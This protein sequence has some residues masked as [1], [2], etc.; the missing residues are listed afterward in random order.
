MNLIEHNIPAG[1]FWLCYC[2]NPLH[3]ILFAQCDSHWRVRCKVRHTPPM[4][5]DPV[6]TCPCGQHD[7]PR[8]LG[9]MDRPSRPHQRRADADS[10]ELGQWTRP[11]ALQHAHPRAWLALAAYARPH[12]LRQQP[13]PCSGYSRG[14]QA[15]L[16]DHDSPGSHALGTVLLPTARQAH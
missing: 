11:L 14:R 13:G 15:P 12:W 2:W 7:P 16:W 1:G 10:V 4:I 5:V 8:R 9:R 3:N 6:V